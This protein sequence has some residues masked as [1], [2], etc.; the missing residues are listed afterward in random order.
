MLRRHQAADLEALQAM[1]SDADARRFNG[2]VADAE[3]T[4][5]YLDQH[6]A[7]FGNG[8]SWKFAIGTST[9][10]MAG[11]CWLKYVES[12]DGFEVGYQV[13]REFWNQGIATEAAEGVVDY[14]FKGVRIPA[15]H[16]IVD[17]AN[18]ASVRV[19]EKLGFARWKELPWECPSG[20]AIIFRMERKSFMRAQP[21]I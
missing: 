14:A 17:P 20:T 7:E 11:W 13:A 3:T 5:R 6:I 18:L 2:G 1:D 15:L 19:A 12:I 8:K 21:L 16:I 4:R 9:G 10:V